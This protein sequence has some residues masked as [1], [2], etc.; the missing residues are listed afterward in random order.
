MKKQSVQFNINKIIKFSEKS[1]CCDFEHINSIFD[2]NFLDNTLKL[3]RNIQSEYSVFS[4]NFDSLY[5]IKSKDIIDIQRK[6]SQNYLNYKLEKIDKDKENNKIPE[7]KIEHSKLQNIYSQSRY[8]S[9]FSKSKKEVLSLKKA[10][11]FTKIIHHL[12]NYRKHELS[13][14]ID[15]LDYLLKKENIPELKNKTSSDFY[16]IFEYCHK[17]QPEIERIIEE[18]KNAPYIKSSL[19]NDFKENEKLLK[20]KK[21]GFIQEFKEKFI[22]GLIENNNILSFFEKNGLNP[23]NDILLSIEIIKNNNTISL[24]KNDDNFFDFEDDLATNRNLSRRTPLF[25]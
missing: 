19:L 10:S 7:L 21:D 5:F 9:I 8:I 22:S 6:C 1:V 25:P 2:G 17:R 12:F 13:C 23:T 15:S 3:I 18:I 24:L 20:S 14:A 11:S 16:S 4:G